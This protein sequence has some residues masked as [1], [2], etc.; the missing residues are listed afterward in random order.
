ML[1]SASHES[2]NTSREERYIFNLVRERVE[3]LPIDN[4]LLGRPLQDHNDL[5]IV[6]RQSND[7]K[8]L[9]VVRH[10]DVDD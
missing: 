2:T 6:S 5:E 3:D 9:V 4:N 1:D 8:V 10:F 7:D